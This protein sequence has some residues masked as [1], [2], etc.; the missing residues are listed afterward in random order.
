MPRSLALVPEPPVGVTLVITGGHTIVQTVEHAEAAP[1][2]ASNRYTVSFFGPAARIVP[3]LLRLVVINP[4]PLVALVAP[5]G[6]FA[7]ALAELVLYPEVDVPGA[8]GAEALV[9]VPAPVA[10]VEEEEVFVAVLAGLVLLV[11]CP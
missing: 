1:L 10:V 2:S 7:V 4:A 11:L 3:N 9:V 5:A 6:A 8:P